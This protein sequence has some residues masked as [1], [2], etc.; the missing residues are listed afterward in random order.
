MGSSSP[1]PLL[2]ELVYD[3]L[4]Q[5]LLLLVET[6]PREISLVLAGL[7]VL[8]VM[9]PLAGLAAADLLVRKVFLPPPRRVRRMESPESLLVETSEANV[10]AVTEVNESSTEELIDTL[11]QLE[12]MNSETASL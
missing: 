2:S 3:S 6:Q 11:S 12:E 5:L 9:T 1:T 7:S 10:R 4:R 8:L